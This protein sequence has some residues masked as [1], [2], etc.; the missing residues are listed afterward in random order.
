MIFDRIISDTIKIIHREKK[1]NN[2]T[3][4]EKIEAIKKVLEAKDSL[5]NIEEA[6]TTL[7]S[8]V[9]IVY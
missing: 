2:M 7:K 8:I 5:K 6:L 3:D 9:Q 1:T 4:T